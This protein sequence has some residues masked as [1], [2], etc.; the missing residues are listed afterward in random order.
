MGCILFATLYGHMPRRSLALPPKPKVLFKR[1]RK[2][3]TNSRYFMPFPT[4]REA[5][6]LYHVAKR[7]MIH[8]ERPETWIKYHDE[9]VDNEYIGKWQ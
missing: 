8:G 9:S 4:H 3:E 5:S 6:Y 1:A 7:V 2:M